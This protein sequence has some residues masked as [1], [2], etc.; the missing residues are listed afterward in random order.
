[1]LAAW[2]AEVALKAR[3]APEQTSVCGESHVPRH[4]HT[5]RH[6]SA[7]TSRRAARTGTCEVE[8]DTCQEV[9]ALRL[10]FFLGLVIPFGM[11]PDLLFSD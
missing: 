8:C 1:M 9:C 5:H 10:V 2:H 11:R 7:V 3:A 4:R 6:V